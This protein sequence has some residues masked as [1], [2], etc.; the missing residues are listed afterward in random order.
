[1]SNSVRKADQRV[2]KVV[3]EGVADEVPRAGAWEHGTACSVPD[4]T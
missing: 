1:M 4:D 3:V 2:L